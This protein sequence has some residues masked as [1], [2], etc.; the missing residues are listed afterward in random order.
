MERGI[1]TASAFA[2]WVFRDTKPFW[3]RYVPDDERVPEEV[4]LRLGS[5]DHAEIERIK[6]GIPNEF[7]GSAAD[8]EVAFADDGSDV[9]FEA[10]GLLIRGVPV[11]GRPDLV[12]KHRSRDHVII[13]ERK[14][15]RLRRPVD[16]KETAKGTWRNIE[17]QLWC[18]SHLD[19]WRDV[20]RVTLVGEMWIR[21]GGVLTTAI[22][23]LVWHKDDRD[24]SDVCRSLFKRYRGMH[25]S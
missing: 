5:M 21:Q 3:Q 12:L 18:Y 8:Y 20:E 9:S 13:V 4:I 14:T 24:H 15:T 7:I 6:A 17:A 11:R 1:A 2:D 10:S 22:E 19:P 23:P 25:S 16:I